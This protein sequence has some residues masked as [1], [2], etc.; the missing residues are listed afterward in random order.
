M[1]KV[2]LHTHAFVR[3]K[4]TPEEMVLSAMKKLMYWAFQPQRVVPTAADIPDS[5]ISAYK[6]E[7]ALKI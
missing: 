4:N 7:I 1:R 3:R 6:A 5:E 2:N